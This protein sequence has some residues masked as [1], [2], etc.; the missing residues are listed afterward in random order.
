MKNMAIG[1][2]KPKEDDEDVPFTSIPHT[3]MEPQV[4]ENEDKDDQPLP[5]HDI[6]ISQEEAQ[7]QAQDVGPPRDTPQQP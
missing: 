3:S 2:I 1:D 7:A 4:D 6:Y 5:S